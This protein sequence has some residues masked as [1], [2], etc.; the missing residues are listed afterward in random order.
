MEEGTP[1][2]GH[3]GIRGN[4]KMA[5][6]HGDEVAKEAAPT[7]ERSLLTMQAEQSHTNRRFRLQA[8]SNRDIVRREISISFLVDDS[9]GRT[10][11]LVDGIMRPAETLGSMHQ[12]PP[13]ALSFEDAQ[14]LMDDLWNSGVRPTDAEKTDSTL[15]ATEMHLN[16][17]RALVF[18]DPRIRA[19]LAK[20]IR[21]I[22][23]DDGT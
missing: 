19:T 8:Y 2:E 15:K 7:L 5:N 21:H 1:K 23:E 14:S 18:E 12:R 10:Y 22:R 16:D 20:S 6:D 11:F 17:L 4:G 9:D 13:I 3:T